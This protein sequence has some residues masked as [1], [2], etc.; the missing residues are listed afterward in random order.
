VSGVEI[1]REIWVSFGRA[2]QGGRDEKQNKKKREGG[3][4][5]NL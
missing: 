1:G 5:E 3:K 2:R 4:E